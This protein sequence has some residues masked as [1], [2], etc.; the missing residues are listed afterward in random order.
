MP[1]KVALA[2]LVMAGPALTGLGGLAS[3]T[4]PTFSGDAPGGVTCTLKAAVSFSPALRVT[5]GGT[6]ASAVTGTLSHCTTNTPAVAITSGT[7]SG[8]FAS[9]PFDC[10][11]LTSTGSFADLEVK[12][13]GSVNGVVGGTTYAGPAAFKKSKIRFDDATMIAGTNGDEGFALPQTVDVS[14][15]FGGMATGNLYTKDTAS[16][17]MAK[18]EAAG[19]LNSL[20]FKGGVTIGEP[21]WPTS[22]AVTAVGGDQNYMTV[23][24]ALAWTLTPDSCTVLGCE[25]QLSS[26][27]SGTMTGTSGP[28]STT[29][30]LPDDT[31]DHMVSAGMVFTLGT[32]GQ[33]YVTFSA[34]SEEGPVPCVGGECDVI[35]DIDQTSGE[36]A[37]AVWDENSELT[38]PATFDAPGGSA[39]FDFIYN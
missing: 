31:P 26:A 14:G 37:T 19:G 16:A 33:Y 12:W 1:L 6:G 23:S 4:T 15:S 38:L 17:L 3:A 32:D 30:T 22:I 8:S 24:Y 5:G 13:E 28:D 7:I 9:S 11:N 39:T 20:S 2:V 35:A 34:S 21:N 18:C 10:A 29:F 25:Y 36:Q 27:I